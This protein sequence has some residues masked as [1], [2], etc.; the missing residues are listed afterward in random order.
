MSAQEGPFAGLSSDH[1]SLISHWME[2]ARLEILPT[3][4]IVK[5]LVGI[6]TSR[7]LTITSPPQKPAKHTLNFADSLNRNCIGHIGIGKFKN[8]MEL[9]RLLNEHP[10]DTFFMV[11]G[12]D[13][14]KNP[15][16][17]DTMQGLNAI[18]IRKHG[19]TRVDVAGYPQGH[20][21]I[22]Q[23]ALDQA[24]R[25]KQQ[26][27]QATGIQMDI[28]TQVCTDHQDFLHWLE[29][30]RQKGITLPV[31]I[32]IPGAVNPET[33]VRFGLQF[34]FKNIQ[35]MVARHPGLSAELT[36]QAIFGYNRDDLVANL[37]LHIKPEHNIS[38]LHI[39]TFN[40]VTNTQRWLEDSMH[41]LR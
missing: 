14:P 4:G 32:G 25:E 9:N 24:L 5:K 6:P 15:N 39:F 3:E 35:R 41:A 22:S 7:T 26:F 19:I 10:N 31:R 30:I 38:G 17:R 18:E 2:T 20:K 36:Q 12:D 27:A 34:G 40:S 23:A 1:K 37:A 16:F 21:D 29:D 11:A 33:L 8:A 13:P 28:V